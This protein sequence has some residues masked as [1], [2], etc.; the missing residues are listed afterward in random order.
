M[1]GKMPDNEIAGEDRRAET[2]DQARRNGGPDVIRT[3]ME[4]DKNRRMRQRHGGSITEHIG[5]AGMGGSGGKHDAG[6][7]QQAAKQQNEGP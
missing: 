5:F 7:T 4:R 6:S 3:D 1:A 2:E